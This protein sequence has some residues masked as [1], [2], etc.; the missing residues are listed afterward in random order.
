MT[1]RTLIKSLTLSVALTFALGATAAADTPA[2][3][4]TTSKTKKPKVK[5]LIFGAGDDVEGGVVRPDGDDV[6][7]VGAIQHSSLIKVREHVI[8]E[9]FKSAEDL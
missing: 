9:I 2:T 6:S 3:P 5:T 4:T 1:I 7:V 8:P